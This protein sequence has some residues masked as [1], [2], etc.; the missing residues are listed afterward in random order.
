VHG[1]NQGPGDVGYASDGRDGL[2]QR[3]DG[4]GFVIDASF[5]V[6]DSAWGD[7][8]SFRG[9]LKIPARESTK[10]ESLEALMRIVLGAVGA[11]DLE[12]P[13][14]EEFRVSFGDVGADFGGPE[15]RCELYGVG[16]RVAGSSAGESGGAAEQLGC[17]EEGSLRD[18]FG[19]GVE[20]TA[21][22]ETDSE[23]SGAAFGH[24]ARISSLR[25]AV[26]WR[27]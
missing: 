20:E 3:S 9:E 24:S 18:G 1:L 4:F 17:E 14:S 27:R 12:P 19:I 13:L 21:T 7:G 10:L 8:E 15:G 11:C 22:Q 23:A 2:D 16:L 6:G 5:P 26:S 25:V